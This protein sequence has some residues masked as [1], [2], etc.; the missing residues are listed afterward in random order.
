MP[1]D[2][3]FNNYGKIAR[4]YVAGEGT[5]VRLKGG[6]TAMN[7]K[8]GYYLLGISHSNYQSLF[9]LVLACAQQGREIHIRTEDNLNSAGSAVAA[10]V[11]VD[12]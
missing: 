12:Y 10:Y 7:P 1:S 9:A 11:T 8:D 2:A 5:Y 6:Q 4:I 3:V